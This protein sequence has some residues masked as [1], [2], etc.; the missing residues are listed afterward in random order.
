MVSPRVNPRKTAEQTMHLE[1]EVLSTS[2]RDGQRLLKKKRITYKST[3]HECCI[4]TWCACSR[5]SSSLARQSFIE[6]LG[7]LSE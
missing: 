3:Q 4:Q 6:P 2:R 5:G 1:S 7:L